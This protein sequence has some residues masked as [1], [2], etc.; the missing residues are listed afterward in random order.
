MVN[1]ESRGGAMTN[2]LSGVMDS[3]I[4]SLLE[5]VAREDREVRMEEYADFLDDELADYLYASDPRNFG[6]DYDE[7]MR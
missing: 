7:G 6:S 2:W 4:N 3:L 5:M 1:V